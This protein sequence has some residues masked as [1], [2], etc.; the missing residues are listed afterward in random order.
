MPLRNEHLPLEATDMNIHLVSSLP[1]P[2][3]GF[4]FFPKAQRSSEPQTLHFCNCA[5]HCVHLYRLFRT[6]PFSTFPLFWN[7]V[8]ISVD[9][10]L[11]LLLWL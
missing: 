1:A 9:V 3:M 10:W 4:I 7:P 11:A 8:R 6:C 5:P 2:L